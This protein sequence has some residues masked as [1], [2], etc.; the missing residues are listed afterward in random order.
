M[1]YLTL[2]LLIIAGAYYFFVLA[3]DKPKKEKEAIGEQS[4]NA[5][6]NIKDIGEKILYTLGGYVVVYIRVYPIAVDLYSEREKEILTR[7]ITL[8]LSAIGNL[9]FK[10]VAVSR[11]VDIAPL[12]REHQEMLSESKNKFQREILRKE[13]MEL[14]RYATSGEVVERQFYFSLWDTEKRK[15]DLMERAAKFSKAFSDN[16]IKVEILKKKDMIRLGN[17]VNHP[18]YVHL[19]EVSNIEATIPVL[20][21]KKD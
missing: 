5:F 12:I 14:S 18:R 7:N 11:P 6:I 1:Q 3:K 20:I 2:F 16:K 8:A 19:E 10:F 15:E 17:M 9:E 4:A 13:I 21:G